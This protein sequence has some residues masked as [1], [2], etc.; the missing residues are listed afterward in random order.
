MIL[1][2]KYTT[3]ESK[4]N[5]MCFYLKLACGYRLPDETLVRMQEFLDTKNL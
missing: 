1:D 4:A 3:L 5:L 2:G